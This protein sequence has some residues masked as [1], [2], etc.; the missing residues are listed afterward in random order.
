[1]SIATLTLAPLDAT[2]QPVQALLLGNGSQ[3]R[4]LVFSVIGPQTG[5]LAS[6][7]ARAPCS[8]HLQDACIA[9]LETTG[10]FLKT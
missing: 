10:Y 4:A 8:G 2:G 3:D 1:M 9:A 6:L 7:K 5:P